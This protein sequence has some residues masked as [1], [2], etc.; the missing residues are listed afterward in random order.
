MTD[1]PIRLYDS[2]A[3][4]ISDDLERYPQHCVQVSIESLPE[5]SALG[6]GIMGF[7]GGRH[8]PNPVNLKPTAEQIHVWMQE[9]NVVGLAAVQ[10]GMVYRTDN[11]YIVDAANLFPEEMHAVINIDPI[12][13]KT[14]P[15]IREL[16]DRGV[17]G[18]RFFP[19]GIRDRIAWLSSPESIAV[20]KLANELGLIVD[21]EAPVSGKKEELIT[22]VEEMAD[23][24]P[25]S[26]IVLDHIFL[27]TIT[28]PDFGINSIYDGLAARDNVYVKWTTANMDIIYVKGAASEDVLRRAVDFFGADKIMWGSA[29]GTCSGT[30]REMVALAHDSTRYLTSDE[31]RKV[32]HDTGRRVFTG[33]EPVQ[34]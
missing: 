27:P 25:G 22:L 18:V 15:M 30:Y 32:L 34:G 14:L 6:P 1:S 9:E 16:A 3:H 21:I 28:D 26:R 31:K 20:W 13:E 29:T 17:V 11:S 4:L 24:F 2:H 23:R 10:K 12:E 5:D 19:I 33:W 8:G 7:P